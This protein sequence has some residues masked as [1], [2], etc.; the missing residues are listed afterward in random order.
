MRC[1]VKVKV[2]LEVTSVEFRDGYDGLVRRRLMG[3]NLRDLHRLG[4]HP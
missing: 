3:L 2:S 4:N 1:L